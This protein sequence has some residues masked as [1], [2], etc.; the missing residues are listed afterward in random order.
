MAYEA[1]TAHEKK[2]KNLEKARKVRAKNLK[3]KKAGKL[4]ATKKKKAAKKV[5]TK[6]KAS[7]VKKV[8]AKVA[9]KKTIKK[10]PSKRATQTAYL[11]AMKSVKTGEKFYFTGEKFDSV[12]RNAAKLGSES[13]AM[14]VAKKWRTKM[15]MGYAMIAETVKIKK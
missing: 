2:L 12:K 4:P 10:N 1:L 5:V 9:T 8:V 13:A 3:L 15:P 11:V 7:P 14:S 6:K